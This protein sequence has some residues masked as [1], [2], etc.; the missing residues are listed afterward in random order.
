VSETV[1][2]PRGFDD[3]RDEDN[4]AAHRPRIDPEERDNYDEWRRERGSR[5]RKRKDK[6]GGC[7]Q[8]RDK[9]D[10]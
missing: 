1:C 6:A 10:F 2:R 5:G 4:N 9:E 7:H 8:F 3:D